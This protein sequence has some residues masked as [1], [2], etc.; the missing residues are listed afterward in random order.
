MA[1]HSLCLLGA[2]GSIAAVQRFHA[3]TDKEALSIARETVKG[4]AELSGFE[5]WEGTRKVN[6]KR[7]RIE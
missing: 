7:Q 2:N 5:V 6:T 3:D 4:H 1:L